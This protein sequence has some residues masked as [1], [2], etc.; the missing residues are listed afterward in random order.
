MST[1]IHLTVT[2]DT[3][4]NAPLL[5]LQVARALAGYSALLVEEAMGGA[6]ISDQ[7]ALDFGRVKMK[8]DVEKKDY[9]PQDR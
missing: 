6:V 2:I 9:E 3:A 8:V 1:K 5:A 7:R 4:N